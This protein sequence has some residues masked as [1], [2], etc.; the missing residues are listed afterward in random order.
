MCLLSV[1]ENAVWKKPKSNQNKTKRRNVAPSLLHLV[2]ESR[3][4]IHLFVS[5]HTNSTLCPHPGV[6]CTPVL[7]LTH[8]PA[9]LLYMEVLFSGLRFQ[10]QNL[11]M[12][13]QARG[14][15]SAAWPT[16]NEQWRWNVL[17]VYIPEKFV[18]QIIG[19]SQGHPLHQHWPS[20]MNAAIVDTV[21]ARL[22]GRFLPHRLFSFFLSFLNHVTWFLPSDIKYPAV[23]RNKLESSS[24]KES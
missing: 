3:R 23:T 10:T 19:T 7:C 9:N 11:L 18:S 20:L 2:V 13:K 14:P 4:A 1:N 17:S 12:G 24:D 5:T 8:V 16:N 6:P 21:P 22:R 15:K